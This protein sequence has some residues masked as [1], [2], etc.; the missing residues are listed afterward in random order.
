M[1]TII[2]GPELRAITL[3]QGPV[4]KASGTL[5]AATISLFTV[6]GGEVLITA[7]WAKV[8]TAITTNGGTL[9]LQTHPTT[10][11]TTTV[12]SATDLGTTDSAAGTPI[13]VAGHTADPAD[14]GATFDRMFVKG[15]AALRDIVVAA[16][17]VELVGASS[18]N[19]AVTV[20]C[21]WIPLTD[22]ATLV[23]S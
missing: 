2:H 14:T 12:V 16:G 13:G 7:L 3:G 19:G 11:D 4:S 15:G 22:G 21:T 18:V 6:A 8:T 1:T 17:A 10:G 5:S 20:F 23:A 9:A